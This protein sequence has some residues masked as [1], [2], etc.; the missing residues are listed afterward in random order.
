MIA[1][2]LKAG[3]SNST[4]GRGIKMK[5]PAARFLLRN[6]L[7]FLLL[8]ALVFSTP[9]VTSAQKV[10]SASS[11]QVGG[12]IFLP[13]VMRNV[14]GPKAQELIWKALQDG[15]IDYPTS[16]LYRAYAMF[17]DPRLPEEY[18]GSGSIDED[19]GLLHEVNANNSQIPGDIMALLKPFMLR[20]DHPNSI[21]SQYIAQATSS[22]SEAS[23]EVICFRENRWAALAS[24]KPGIKIKVWAPCT[25]D[26][27][28]DIQYVLSMMEGLWG[29]MTS[30][31]GNPKPDAGGEDGGDSDDIDIYLWQPGVS[32]P[33][34]GNM[35]MPTGAAGV[36]PT[37]PPYL[38]VS[39]SGYILLNRTRLGNKIFRSELVHEFFHILQHAH[40]QKIEFD[41]AQNEWW[42][43][44]ASAK[45]AESYFAR[46]LSPI[47]VHPWF[48]AGFQ[49]S[50]ESL[51]LSVGTKHPK[52][53][54]LYEAYIWPFFMQQ[55]VGAES[56]A[57]VWFDLEGAGENWKTGL[58]LIE[59][60]LPFKQ[61]FRRFAI[62]NVNLQLG[63][64]NPIDPRYVD[65]DPGFPDQIP[66][67]PKDT[68]ILFSDSN[69]QMYFD[70]VPALKAFY[71]H[72]YFTDDV[73]KVE[74]NLA[75]LAMNEN[76]NVDAVVKIR[77]QGWQLRE[78]TGK[79]SETL[80]GVEEMYLVVSNHDT[81]IQTQTMAIFT[82]TPKETPCACEDIAEVQ[83][84]NGSIYYAYNHQAS[85]SEFGAELNQTAN[86]TFTIDQ[87]SAGPGGVSYIGELSGNA[88]INDTW[89]D[90]GPPPNVDNIKASG[91]PL[92]WISDERA[93]RATLNI[94]LIDCTYNFAMTVYLN[95][96]EGAL[97]EVG[98]VRSGDRPIASTTTLNGSGW[99]PAH[100]VV[101]GTQNPGEAYSP[102]G[103]A[104]PMFFMIHE[105]N[106]DNAG[107]AEVDW[108]FS[109][110]FP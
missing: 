91:N 34:P 42:W 48:S 80:C 59:A 90:Y 51:H 1:V 98:T 27:D 82:V 26:F 38:G 14:A 92:N 9:G 83:T 105:W 6:L 109:P 13:L 8:I 12:E 100:S 76:I 103:F 44:E 106:E 93:S 96:P 55:E 41:A 43:V 86:V 4:T 32:T 5:T 47:A 64:G 66:P 110:V 88:A 56:I 21:F 52:H 71:Y 84:W 67:R 74:L 95:G 31:M 63:P 57:G 87:S 11:S 53:K 97:F 37:A 94:N 3:P 29:S 30:F 50:P 2:F 20:P 24:T 85:N 73:G 22:L 72:Y 68:Q 36:A 28:A 40:N 70:N 99:F 79:S 65:L 108:S 16:L 15:R 107:S 18:W 78:L 101:W 7:R 89:I 61:H 23:Q 62:R 33:R 17:G 102:G 35:E 104:L 25:G 75:A 58:G 60:R 81:D 46:D 10:E 49:S 54:H 19:R 45:W 39:S 77:D 69:P